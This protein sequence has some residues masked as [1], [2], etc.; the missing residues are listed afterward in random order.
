MLHKSSMTKNYSSSI[1]EAISSN[2]PPL[3]KSAIVPM[4]NKVNQ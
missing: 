2:Q 4:F 1:R 3:D